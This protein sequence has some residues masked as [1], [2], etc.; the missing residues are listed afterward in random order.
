MCMRMIPTSDNFEDT[1]PHD[2]P[3]EH[4]G[5][6][7]VYGVEN[8][9]TAIY[10][11]LFALQH[12]G[13]EGAGMVVSDGKILHFC[14][15]MGLVSEVFTGDFPE[16]LPGKVGIGHVRYST[17][18]ASR[19]A[20]VQPFLAECRDGM[21]AV[22]H[23][24]NL[25]NA[26]E[27][28]DRYQKQGAIF[29]TTTDSEILLHQLADPAFFGQKDRI[30]KALAELRGSFAFVIARPNC[31][32]AARDP[33]GIRPLSIG[34]LG[35]GYVVA[36]ETCAMR[37]IGAEYVRDVNPGELIKLDDNGIK[38][39][40]FADVPTGGY[41]QCVFEHIY[42]AR[43][44]SHVFGQS[45]YQVRSAIGK[46]LAVEHPVAADLVVPI[47]DSGVLAAL[48]YSHE[49]G[50]PF[51][52]GFIRNHYVGRTFIMPT[53]RSRKSG[54]DLKLSVVPEVVGGRRVVLVD[55]SIIRGTTIQKRIDM[56]RNAGAKEV[57]V[58]ISC[59]P[60][61]YPCFF[62]IDFPEAS[63]LVAS[64]R[65]EEQICRLCGA[66]SVG[67]LSLDGLKSV[68]KSP[69]HFCYGCFTGRYMC[70][71]QHVVCKHALERGGPE[72]LED[73]HHRYGVMMQ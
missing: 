66:D 59:P 25:V 22:A 5:V 69:E 2:A 8:A 38:S 1:E 62:G 42:F 46:R 35:K 54:V 23:N 6:V 13:Q 3:R 49:S 70:E 14:K 63:E 24:G 21:W 4:C 48:G 52:M 34:K 11:G 31:V 53:Q 65:S 18:G 27:L 73:R 56:L 41:G 10:N 58:R 15:G 67:Y 28:R 32:Y 40:R 36:S 64:G 60:T 29:Q 47:P 39:L 7:A 16:H 61:R 71:T 30:R 51:E 44:D 37:Q 17:T 57:H 26:G 33:W 20:N 19:S 43:P 50:I 12:R 55:D 72:N 9:A 45:V 68:L